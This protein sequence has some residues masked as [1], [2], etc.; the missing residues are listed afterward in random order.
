MRARVRRPATTA[1]LPRHV[2]V[3]IPRTRDPFVNTPLLAV[4]PDAEGRD[5]FW[6]SS[7]NAVEGCFGVLVDEDGGRRIYRPGKRFPGFYSAVAAGPDTLWLCG[8][9]DA[10]VELTLSTGT[11]TSYPTGA[12]RDLVFQGMILDP[13][14]RKLF[15]AA[16]CADGITAFSFDTRSKKTVTIHRRFTPDHYMRLSF[17]NGDGTWSALFQTPGESLVR[18]DP[19]AETLTHDVLRPAIDAHASANCTRRLIVDD[20]GRP[21]LPGQGWFDPR[22]RAWTPAPAAARSGVTWVVRS[23]RTAYGATSEQ[24]DARLLAWDM[25]SGAIR[26]LPRIPDCDVLHINLTA[27]GKLVA[28]NTYGVFHR[29][30]A[31]TGALEMVR[32]LPTDAIGHVDCVCRIDRDRLLGTPFITQR[33][34]EA[35]LSTGT[36]V[37]CGRAAPA[38]GEVLRTW[39]LGGKVYMAAY[40]GGELTEYDPRRPARFP[41][42]PRVV[43]KAPGGLRPVGNADDGRNLYYSCSAGYGKLGSVLT[44]YDTK[45]GL[46]SYARDPLPQQQLRSL[47]YDRSARALL[48]ASTCFADM[49]SAPPA[50]KNCHIARI[51]ADDLAVEQTA[52]APAGT[53]MPWVVGPLGRGR[54]LCTFSP[55]DWGRKQDRWAAIDIREL[56]TPRTDE[57][58]EFPAGYHNIVAARTPGQFVLQIEKRIEL[59][60]MRAG[61]S[62]RVLWPDF[63]GYRIFAQGRS[64]YLFRAKEIVVLDDCL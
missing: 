17:A 39:L 26:E 27:A 58:R 21:F 47:G 18:W 4:G 24:G 56:R 2:R 53:Q 38:S 46:A 35:R 41:E 42:N 55:L 54:W 61:E 10:V 40:T 12:P 29:L 14:T 49:N 5:R 16:Y 59:W 6:I 33:F 50:T 51:S 28:V 60:D 11:F 25:D 7:Y 13:A 22:T 19:L 52:E 8:T 3:P 48:A 15:M 62:L 57:L 43:A 63:D 30:D 32:E 64:L 9:L 45:T 34:W 31:A 44:K 36:G 23:G 1:R 37:D 20:Q